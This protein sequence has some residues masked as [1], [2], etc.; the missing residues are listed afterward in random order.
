MSTDFEQ[1]NAEATKLGL[2]LQKKGEKS[3]WIALSYV[4]QS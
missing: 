3:G 2:H 1:I 4:M